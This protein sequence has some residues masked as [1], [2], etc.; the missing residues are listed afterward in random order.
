MSHCTVEK[1]FESFVSRK[2][3]T[4]FYGEINFQDDYLLRAIFLLHPCLDILALNFF[5][6]EQTHSINLRLHFVI[7]LL[8]SHAQPR[9]KRF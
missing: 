6:N 8:P 5:S 4:F 9:T 7:L 1:R 2:R 3:I